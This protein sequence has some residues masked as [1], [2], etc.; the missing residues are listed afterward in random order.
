MG[1]RSVT[2]AN[3]RSGRYEGHGA[4]GLGAIMIIVKYYMD[5]LVQDCGNS[6]A[7]GRTGVTAAL[8]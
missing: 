7:S 6:S 1:R 4:R 2:R 5:G 3:T 8:C